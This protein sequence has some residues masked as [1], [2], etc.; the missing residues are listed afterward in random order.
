MEY[1]NFTASLHHNGSS[2]HVSH[3]EVDNIASNL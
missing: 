3:R 2:K 1:D